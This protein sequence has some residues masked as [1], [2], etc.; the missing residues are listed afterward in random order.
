ME[1]MRIAMLY[2]LGMDPAC[3][4]SWFRREFKMMFTKLAEYL[5]CSHTGNISI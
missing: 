4:D 3:V 2:P 1:K 5:A